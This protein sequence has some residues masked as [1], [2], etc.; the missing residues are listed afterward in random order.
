M[1]GLRSRLSFGDYGDKDPLIYF[2][3]PE[4]GVTNFHSIGSIELTLPEAG[5]VLEP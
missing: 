3:K 4:A 5:T 2:T 1:G